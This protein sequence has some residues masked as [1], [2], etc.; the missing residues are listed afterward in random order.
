MG[1][2]L[3]AEPPR[4]VGSHAARIKAKIGIEMMCHGLRIARKKANI[5]S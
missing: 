2:P 1:P 5:N 4:E 3:V